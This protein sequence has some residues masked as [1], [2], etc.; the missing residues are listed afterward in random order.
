MSKQRF[1]SRGDIKK[2]GS[3]W[4]TEFTAGTQTFMTLAYILI[5]QP[6][7]MLGAGL[8]EEIIFSATTVFSLFATLSMGV[9]GRFPFALSTGMGSNIIYVSLVGSGQVTWQEGMGL[10]FWAGVIFVIT[11]IPFGKFSL[12]EIITNNIP[13]SIKFGLG[14][15]VGLF[16]A[17]L[18]FSNAGLASIVDNTLTAGSLRNPL[19]TVAFIGLFVTCFLFFG[20]TLLEKKNDSDQ[21][22]SKWSLP[23]AVLLGIL[24]VTVVLIIMEHVQLP[25]QPF[26]I[27]ANPFALFPALVGSRDFWSSV[28]KVQNWPYIFVFFLS[29]M[30]STIGTSLGCAA[31]AGFMNPETG[32]VPGIDRIFIIDAFFTVVGALFGLTT[33]TTFVESAAGVEAGGRTGWTSVFTSSWFFLALFM[34]PIFLMIPSI[35]TGIA[36][37]VVGISMMLCLENVNFKNPEEVVPI[38]FMVAATAFTG[39]FAIALCMGLIIYPLWRFFSWLFYPLICRFNNKAQQTTISAFPAEDALQDEFLPIT[40]YSSTIHRQLLPT[41]ASVGIA[42]IGLAN[43]ILSA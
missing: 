14:A 38:L 19:V 21:K 43:L 31:K 42:V 39:D 2:A 7:I 4:G 22:I 28:L 3:S 23:G 29:D 16:L 37:I 5:V 20:F 11:S 34:S 32:E 33:I 12:R 26:S 17:N 27:P 9:F 36:L 6:M 8:P 25:D 13:V 35:A 41:V 24:L 1:L 40:G 18:G 15:I 30:F 10:V